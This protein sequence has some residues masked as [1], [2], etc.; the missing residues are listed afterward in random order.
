MNACTNLDLDSYLFHFLFSGL[1]L[2]WTMTFDPKVHAKIVTYDIFAC[3]ENV[4]G[5]VSS[6]GWNSLGRVK[7]LPLPMACTLT[8]FKK[9][10]KYH[11][12]VQATDE[13]GRKADFADVESILLT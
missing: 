10:F 9:G 4:Q 3:E 11:L 5:L 2:S 12:T 6:G 13:H 1:V 8:K 7:A